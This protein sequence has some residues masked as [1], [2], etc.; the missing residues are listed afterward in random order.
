MLVLNPAVRGVAGVAWFY[1]P[2]L[3]RVSPHLSYITQTLVRREA[4]VG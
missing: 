1:D 4:G 3:L 2:E